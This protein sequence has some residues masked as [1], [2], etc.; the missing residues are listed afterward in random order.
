MK[1]FLYA[2]FHYIPQSTQKQRNMPKLMHILHTT[3]HA[4]H[5]RSL[6]DGL[7]EILTSKNELISLNKPLFQT[8][9][10]MEFK[11]KCKTFEVTKKEGFINKKVSQL[12][13]AK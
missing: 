12:L 3:A 6:I 9:F 1:L 2:C 13:R 10:N 5:G 4:L 7:V 8:V 11:Y